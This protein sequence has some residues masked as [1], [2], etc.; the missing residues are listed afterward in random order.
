MLSSLSSP[1]QRRAR[2]GAL[3]ERAP[4]LSGEE[5]ELAL[6]QRWGS[7]YEQPIAR[8]TEVWNLLPKKAQEDLTKSGIRYHPEFGEY[9]LKV[10]EHMW[11]GRTDAGLARIKRRGLAALASEEA[12]KAAAG[13]A[14]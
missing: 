11:D 2:L 3:A 1:S 5:A 6:E 9:L 13:P 8:A 10:G 7:R 14:R 4:V 12:K